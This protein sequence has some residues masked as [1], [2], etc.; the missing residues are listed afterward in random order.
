MFGHLYVHRYS[1]GLGKIDYASIL[2]LGQTNQYILFTQFHPLPVGPKTLLLSPNSTVYSV[3]IQ[4]TS[5]C[6][7]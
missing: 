3:N 4:Q 7:S 2:N 6:T 5:I 1:E